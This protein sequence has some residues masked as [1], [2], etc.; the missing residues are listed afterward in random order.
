MGKIKGI[1]TMWQDATK[2]KKIPTLRQAVEE[3]PD[4]WFSPP[5]DEQQREV[6]DDN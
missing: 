3:Y 6:E 1:V 4:W 2:S 5:T